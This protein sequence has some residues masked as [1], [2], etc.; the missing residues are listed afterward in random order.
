MSIELQRSP[1]GTT[2]GGRL[3]EKFTFTHGNGLVLSVLNLGCVIQSL[4]L[5]DKHGVPADVVLGYDT[6]AEYQ[7][8]KKFL[9]CVVGRYANRIAHGRFTLD[10]V[11][12]QLE[13]N[14]AGHHIH[15]GAD[16]F[17]KQVWHAT[18]E[19]SENSPKLVL[20]HTS[21][22]RHS[23]Y[24]GRLECRVTF[25][26]T[27]DGQLQLTY[28][29]TSDRPTIINLTNHSYFNLAG[30]EYAAQNGV[31]DHLLQLSCDKYIPTDSSGIP[32]SDPIAVDG[33]PMDFRKQTSFAAR[34]ER[35]DQQLINAGGYDHT[36]EV[37][38][39]AD[40]NLA[41]KLTD[42][43]SGR[44]LQV[45]TTQPGIQVYTG[46]HVD[47]IEGKG[48]QVY[49]YRGAVCLET[50]HFPD[51]PNRSSYPSVLLLPDRAYTHTTVFSP[52]IG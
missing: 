19:Q 29:A 27:P 24:P 51:S 48:G 28:S 52:G 40:L 8:D 1:F 46:N 31:L 36:W 15:G 50:Q 14:P 16:G 41:A 4:Q 20:S 47:N 22:H 44:S 45:S 23:G 33:T 38:G 49:Q 3:V 34:I 37:A 30:H 21:P 7:A 32:L 39:D 12:Y 9:G 26:I 42:P 6:L 17:H 25:A 10:G 2:A 13:T 43:V 11:G 5:P 35:A 18:V